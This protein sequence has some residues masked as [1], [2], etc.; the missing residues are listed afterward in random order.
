MNCEIL[1]LDNI[2]GNE[3]A[4]VY[5]APSITQR[6]WAFQQLENSACNLHISFYVSFTSSLLELVIFMNFYTG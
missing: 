4:I 2:L 5:R 6:G 3:E 1:N